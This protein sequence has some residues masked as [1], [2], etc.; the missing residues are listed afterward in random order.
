MCRFSVN[1]QVKSVFTKE[2]PLNMTPGATS[3]YAD[4][5]PIH[6]STAGITKLLQKVDCKKASGSDGI[7]CYI[8]KEA[9]TELAP[10]L[11]FLFTQSLHKGS[12]PQAWLKAT[13][14]PV[15]KKGNRSQVDNYQPISLT[16]L[17]RKIMGHVIFR[18]MMS[19]LDSNQ[20]LVNYLKLSTWLS[21]K[22]VM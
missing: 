14:L 20:V 21:K 22:I 16:S 12:V 9:A 10:F 2:D 11:Q 6:F 19:N 17:P 3:P 4:I 8:L 7:P 5:P 1:S 15:H 18:E 13:V